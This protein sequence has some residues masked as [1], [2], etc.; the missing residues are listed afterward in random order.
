MVKKSNKYKA[1]VIGTSAG[2]LEA[3]ARVLPV[4]PKDFPVPVFI[5]QHI[6]ASS[7]SYLIEYFDRMCRIR[8]KEAED[9]EQV[10][11]GTVYFAPPDYHLLI[12]E[13]FSLSLSNAEKINYSRPSI[14]VLFETAV[15][16][17][18]QGLIGLI[19]TGANEDGA[20]GLSQIKASGGF[21]IVENPKT[22]SVPRMPEA[23]IEKC[24]VDLILNVGEI[25]KRINKLML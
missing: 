6:S 21:T 16:A 4:L 9:K 11:P 22:A 5:V 19:M 1:I 18:G 13:D 14:D 2:G 23:A 24:Q 8:V 3:L 15:W 12:E 25:G 10:R 17:Y 7:D 20:I